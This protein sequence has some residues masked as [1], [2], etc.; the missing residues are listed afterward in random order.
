[1]V[2]LDIHIFIM[3]FYIRRAYIDPRT[4]EIRYS[5]GGK[6]DYVDRRKPPPDVDKWSPTRPLSPVDKK[7]E[8]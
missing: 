5:K 2:Y 3:N 6:R 1:M 4:G 7:R 8:N